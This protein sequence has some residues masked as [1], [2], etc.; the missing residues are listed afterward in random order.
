M[1]N[2]EYSCKIVDTSRSTRVLASL[3]LWRHKRKKHTSGRPGHRS[4]HRRDSTWIA[5]Y[6]Y[7]DRNTTPNTAQA[8]QHHTAVCARLTRPYAQGCTDTTCE[9][10]SIPRDDSA[11]ASNIHHRAGIS[12]LSL[13]AHVHLTVAVPALSSCAHLALPMSLSLRST[14][15]V[16]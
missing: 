8:Q 6:S 10:L 9:H 14:C 4:T 5:T 16:I 13:R 15:V 12:D 1:I 3:W 2:V 11:A 7:M